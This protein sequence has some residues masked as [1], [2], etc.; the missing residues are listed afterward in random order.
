MAGFTFRCLQGLLWSR[1]KEDLDWQK[2]RNYVIHQILAYGNLTEI[3]QLV[4]KYN[5]E[6]IIAEFTHLPRQIYTPQAFNFVK[7][8]LL[9]LADRQID[10]KLYVKTVF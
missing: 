9:P 5:Q 3:K 4:K 10:P 8:F 1:K 2:D 6:E 7:N